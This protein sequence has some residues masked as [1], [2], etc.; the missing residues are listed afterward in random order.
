LEDIIWGGAV[1]RYAREYFEAAQRVLERVWKTQEGNMKSA[2]DAMTR[3]AA[4]GGVV[5]VFGAG[6]TQIICQEVWFRAGQPACVSPVFDE[7]LF[8]YNGPGKGS[9]LEKLEGYGRVIFN[10]H[11]ARPGEVVIVISNSGR[12]AAPIE[13]ALAAKEK[14]LTVV[15]ITSMDYSTRVSSKHSSRKRL[16]E[17]ADI[18]IDNGGPEGDAVISVEGMTGRAGPITTIANAA[19]VNAMLAQMAADIRCLGM[20]NPVFISANLDAPSSNNEKLAARYRERIKY[21]GG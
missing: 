19:I 17:V 7:G 4:S 10:N 18:V 6:H 1:L 15:G 5:H 8:P 13:V 2:V 20:E 14:G 9:A 21:Y 16:F 11:D 12:N 3:V